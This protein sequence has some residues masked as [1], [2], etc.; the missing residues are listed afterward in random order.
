M[1]ITEILN[2]GATNVTF[3]ISGSDL[4]EFS[5]AL[6]AEARTLGSCKP[7][8]EQYL[9][10]SEVAKLLNVSENTLWRWNRDGYLQSVKIG[11]NPFYKQSDIDRLRK[12]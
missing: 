3:A 9:S 10:K 1:N 4:K 12:G 11:R 7:E 8:E 6:I 5:L 2:S